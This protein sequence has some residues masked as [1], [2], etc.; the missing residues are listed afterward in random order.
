MKFLWTLRKCIKKLK[1][2]DEG[3]LFYCRL[4]IQRTTEKQAELFSK[5]A[6]PEL[7]VNL[8]Y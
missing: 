2:I 1:T 4:L 6:L 5:H 3:V 7:F 8:N